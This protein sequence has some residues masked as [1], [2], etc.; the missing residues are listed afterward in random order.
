MKRTCVLFLLFALAASAAAQEPSVTA[1]PA[2]V[3]IVLD[4]VLDEPAWEH[5]GVIS[6]LTQ[7]DPEPGKPTPYTT[8]IAVL[9]DGDTLYF[10][11]TAVDPE[12]AK[13]AVH[14]LQRDSDMAGD[15]TV[16]LVLDTFGDG[17]TGYLFRVNAGGARQDGLISGAQEISLDWDGIWDARVRRTAAGWTAEIAIPARSLRFRPG[18]ERWGF[19]VERFVARDRLT[20]RWAGATLDANLSD[21]K[22]TGRLA[23]VSGLRQGLG[24][25]FAPYTLGRA[26]DERTA[27]VRE[28]G[29]A[30]FDLS[31]NLTPG[32]GA[33]LTANTDFAET[34]VDARQ[35]NLTRFPLFFPEKR[36]FFLEG[37]NLFEF[38]YGLSESLI[39]FYSRRVGLVSGRAVPI[40]E[41]LKVLGRAGPWAIA[42]LDV[43]TGDDP[44]A[45]RENLFAGRLTYDVDEHLRVGGLATRGDPTGARDNAFGGLDAVWRTSSFHGDKNLVFAAW[46]A[47]SAGDL[48]PGRDTGWGL[49]AAYPNDLWDLSLAVKEFGEALDPAL[50]FLPRPGRRRYDGGMAFQPRPREDGPFGWVRQFFFE[51]YPYR[52]DRLDGTT[53]SWRV[54]MAPFNV[55]TRSG[56]HLEANWAPQFER[57]DAPFEVA[58]GVVIPPGAYHFNRFRVEAQS[59]EARAWSVGSTFWFGEFFAGHLTQWESFVNWTAGP[60]RL[61]FELSA[62]NDFGYLPE[63][64]FIQRLLQL[65][66]LY[67]F[68]PDLLLSAFTQYDSESRGLGLNSRLRWTIRPGRDLFLVWNRNWRRLPRPA[69]RFETEADQVAVKLRWTSLW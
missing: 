13:I 43:E 47:R 20:L 64:D 66:T 63:G 29:E 7:Q 58:S 21:L 59:S 68:S 8:R 37:S 6:D 42:A 46:G 48:P 57:L 67:A 53:E 60:G 52:V 25:S 2:E 12:P 36:P 69:D 22:R 39:P 40:D 32:L 14:T 3:G 65:K 11:V 5:A 41:G 33:V 55:R 30:G 54:F 26:D 28:K 56:E 9:A 15:D 16:A 31:Y 34:E 44:A 19:N 27:P 24:L 51:L 61:R 62:E 38:S 45:P 10:G 49:T 18:L 35:I 50:G 23:G 1:G 17:R 4:G